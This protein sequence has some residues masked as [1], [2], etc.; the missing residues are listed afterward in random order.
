MSVASLLYLP[1]M[2]VLPPLL[3]GIIR[4]LKSRLQ[5]RRGPSP[6]QPIWDLVKGLRKG[7]TVSATTTW[8][9]GAAP[10]VALGS[11]VLVALSVPWLGL[12]SPWHGDLFLLVYLLALGKLA[13]SLG[14]LDP[15]STFGAL[16]ASRE[17]AVSVQ[18]EPAMVLALGA[19]AVHAGSSDL[20]VMLAPGQMGAELGA[21]TPLVLAALWLAVCAELARMPFDDPTTHLELTMIHEA[22]VL[23]NSG[24]SLALVELGVA[25]KLAVLLGLLAQVMLMA[26]PALTAWGA[27]LATLALMLGSCGVVA[28]TETVMVRLRW[29]RI[30]NL[31]AFGLTASVM[32]CLLVALKG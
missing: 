10:L 28:V 31:L 17:A 7:E 30:P 21:V 5:G 13:V 26:W 15:G 14:A 25:I 24:R 11:S 22:L 8:V 20:S 12:P 29:R 16:G 4:T 27:H 1:Y 32:A 2:V 9:F 3:I 19:L 23:E 6:L 18:S